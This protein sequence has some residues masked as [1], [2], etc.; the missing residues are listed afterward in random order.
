MPTMSDLNS[1]DNLASIDTTNGA[2]R[3]GRLNAGLAIVYRDEV[4]VGGN[5]PPK[6]EWWN[7]EDFLPAT[8]PHPYTLRSAVIMCGGQL[9][10]ETSL[11]QETRPPSRSA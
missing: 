7:R 8:E 10:G 11:A 9:T 4:K 5:K 1:V 3:I 2:R 6:R